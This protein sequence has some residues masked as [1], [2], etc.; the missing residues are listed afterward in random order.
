[1]KTKLSPHQQKRR[2]ENTGH[3]VGEAGAQ[4][5]IENPI[6]E[7]RQEDGRVRLWGELGGEYGT[8]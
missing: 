2:T 7:E 6:A 1:M 3:D 4:H 8:S 5:I